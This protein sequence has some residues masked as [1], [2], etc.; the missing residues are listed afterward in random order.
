[1]SQTV[2]FSS[3]FLTSLMHFCIHLCYASTHCW[4]DSSGMPINSVMTVLLM[5][6][7]PYTQVPFELGEKKN[8]R[9]KSQ[10]KQVWFSLKTVD[11]VL[12]HLHMILLLI[13]TQQSWHHFVQ[14][15]CLPKSFIILQ[16]LSFFI[17][18][19]VLP[20]WTKSFRFIHFLMLIF[21]SKK[22]SYIQK[23]VKKAM[24]TEI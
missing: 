10:T 24:V 15:S 13:I 21:N 4:K 7:M 20:N 18:S 23:H 19:W 22:G 2:Y 11:H 1:M 9:A 3:K 14:S 12:A 16:T 5:A 8:Y 6:S 17:S